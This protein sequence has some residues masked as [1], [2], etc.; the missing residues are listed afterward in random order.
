MCSL[1]VLD[2]G[3]QSLGHFLVPGPSLALD[4]GENPRDVS[5][6]YLGAG[7][8][9]RDTHLPEEVNESL[10]RDSEIVG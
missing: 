1:R 6:T 9:Y 8:R 3:L 2:G 10:C 4:S 5:L 7:I